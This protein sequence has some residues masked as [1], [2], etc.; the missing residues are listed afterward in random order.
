MKQFHK[1]LHNYGTNKLIKTYLSQNSDQTTWTNSV[2]GTFTYDSDDKKTEEEY[3]VWKNDAWL[4]S[5]KYL[6][7][8]VTAINAGK[9][10]FAG[11]SIFSLVSYQSSSK[12]NSVFSFHLTQPSKL[13]IDIY[14]L[15]GS[16][17]ASLGKKMGSKSITHPQHQS[18]RYRSDFS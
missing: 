14:D 12:N 6:Y 8:Y 16:I 1:Q 3:K 7:S 4:N 2:Q 9:E 10:I 11:N 13:K 5:D 18:L 17:I 15:K